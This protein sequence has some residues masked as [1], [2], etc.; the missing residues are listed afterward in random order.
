MRKE[1]LGLI[2]LSMLAC[3]TAPA[4]AQV[5]IGIGLPHVSIGINLP[6]Y[7]EFV[8]VRGYPVYY[9]PGVNSNYFFY[10]G[11]YWVYQDDYW[12]SSSWY[13]GPWGAVAPEFVPEFI[14]R[15]PVSYY[16]RPPPYFRG[17]RPDAAPRWGD[18]YGHEWAQRRN[19]WDRWDRNRV[20]AAAPLPVYQRRYSGDRYPHE[21]QQ[22]ELHSQNYRY[23][24]RDPVVRERFGGE[25]P[26]GDD[27][28][29]SAAI[30]GGPGVRERAPAPEARREQRPA[31]QRSG[32]QRRGKEKDQ[33]KGDRSDEHKG[34][35]PG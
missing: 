12:Y 4:A 9:A 3:A 17:W 6:V 14:L 21:Q 35:R 27:R 22:H 28:R 2:V 30:Q 1:Y 34:S 8:P 16:R 24:P 23:Q 25:A 31:E 5:S 32:E 29:R 20:P 26:R 10:D 11:M 19:G 13:N 15:V 7:P 18:H 33:D